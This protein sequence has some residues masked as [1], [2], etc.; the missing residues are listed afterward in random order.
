MGTYLKDYY[1]A[2]EAIYL[3]IGG[4]YYFDNGL[5]GQFALKTHYGKADYIELGIG[6]SFNYARHEK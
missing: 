2:D 5:H 4:R 6:Y 3:K 1:K